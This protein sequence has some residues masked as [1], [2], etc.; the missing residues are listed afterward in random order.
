MG[1]LVSA[2]T[3]V[4]GAFIA[5]SPTQA[6]KIWG[7][8]RLEKAAPQ[9]RVFLFRWFRILGILLCLAGVLLAIDGIAFSGHR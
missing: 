6:A 3:I 5:A 2:V 7:S 8:E 4:L 9:D 1:L